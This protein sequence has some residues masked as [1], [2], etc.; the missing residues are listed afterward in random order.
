MTTIVCDKTEMACDLQY[1]KTDGSCWRG[2]TKIYKF[3]PHR[4]TWEHSKFIMGFAGTASDIVSIAAFY[5]NPEMFKAPPKTSTI[6]GLV[7]TDEGDIYTFDTHT[8]WLKVNEPFAAIGS[9]GLIALGALS[10]GASLREAIKIAS[11][12]DVYTG[13]GL[14]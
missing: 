1:T 6:R 13:M 7:L 5:S 2:N 10:A 9:G 8:K 3:D 14:S 12:S 4:L 11:K